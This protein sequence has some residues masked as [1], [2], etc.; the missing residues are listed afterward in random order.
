MKD[1]KGD[2]LGGCRSK[3]FTLVELIVVIVIIGILA[4][5]VSRRVIQHISKAKTTA[6]RA[7]IKIFEGAVKDYYMDTS[8]YPEDLWD[9]VQEPAGIVGWNRDGYLDAS[10][11]PPDPWGNEY[12]YQYPGEYAKFDIF[13][14]GA[15][16]EEGGDDED[17]DIYNSDVRSVAGT[18]EE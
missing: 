3:G 10:E 2:N 5:L 6:A 14:L 8:Q 18:A 13:S 12:Y 7:Q 16:G 1:R 17:G 11:I 4:S 15:D 9:L